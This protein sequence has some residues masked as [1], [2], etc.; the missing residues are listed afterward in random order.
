VR[1]LETGNVGAVYASL[2][3]FESL[4][5]HASGSQQQ[6]LEMAFVSDIYADL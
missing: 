5:A 2:M 6:E 1:G 4:L 3:D